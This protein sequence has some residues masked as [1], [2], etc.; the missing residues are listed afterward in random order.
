MNK[1]ILLIGIV[2]ILLI[3]CSNPKM[4]LKCYEFKELTLKTIDEIDNYNARIDKYGNNMSYETDIKAYNE[5]C[6][7]HTGEIQS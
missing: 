3:G 5:I 6:K 2:L 1:T 4:E 7:E